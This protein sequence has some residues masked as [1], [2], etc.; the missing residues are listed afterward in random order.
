MEIRKSLSSVYYFTNGANEIPFAQL[1]AQPLW[2]SFS[3]TQGP[4]LEE[5]DF[6]ANLGLWLRFIF[7][8][9]KQTK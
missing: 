3:Y 7:V 9:S 5:A 8:R 2:G 6:T 1:A 4:L